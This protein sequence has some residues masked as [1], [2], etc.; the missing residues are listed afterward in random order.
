MDKDIYHYNDA[1]DKYYPHDGMY[2]KGKIY[3]SCG[4]CKEHTRNKGKRRQRD[5]NYQPSINYKHSDIVKI[6]KMEEQLDE[7]REGEV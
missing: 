7:M 4:W 2:S 5:K 1:D 6:Q 3:C